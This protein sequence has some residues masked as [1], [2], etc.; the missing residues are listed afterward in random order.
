MAWSRQQGAVGA[1]VAVVLVAGV[2]GALLADGDTGQANRPA[3]AQ[4]W[5]C[6]MAY[7]GFN[8][9]MPVGTA[10]YLLEHRLTR[11]GY[12]PRGQAF[13]QDALN[14]LR[15][16]DP[17]EAL[18]SEQFGPPCEDLEEGDLEPLSSAFDDELSA[19]AIVRR[20]DGRFE[21]TDLDDVADRLLL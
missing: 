14:D 5:E 9:G 16:R 10:T 3:A 4:S 8:Q 7:S 17:R 12:P 6:L 19:E 2:L 11:G 18:G 1:L 13:F 21:E 20:D 15:D